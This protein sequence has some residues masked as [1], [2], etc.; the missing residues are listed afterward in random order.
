MSSYKRFVDAARFVDKDL[1]IGI[2][3]DLTVGDIA[4]R[5]RI[6][7]EEAWQHVE[8]MV[9]EGLARIT[10]RKLGHLLLEDDA[11]RFALQQG[12]IR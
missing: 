3:G 11:L 1:G 6:T 5:A 8:R 4:A 12:D 7:V 10:N 2:S 9:R